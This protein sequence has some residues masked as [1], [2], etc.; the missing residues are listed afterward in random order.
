MFTTLSG[1]GY[2]C[3]MWL[4]LLVG[5]DVL[6]V[7][8]RFF[9]LTG[10]LA[11]V[12]VTTGLLSSLF[13]LKHPERAWRALSQWQSSWLS[14]EGVAAIITFA[15]TTV[16]TLSWLFGGPGAN[17]AVALGIAM[18]LCSGFTLYC[19][20][21]IYASIKAVPDWASGYTVPGYLL[22]GLAGGAVVVCAMAVLTAPMPVSPL[23]P[24]GA[25]VLILSAGLYKL[26]VWS[27]PQDR[28]D[29]N[30]GS[31]LG[32]K[33]RARNVRLVENPSTS[34]TWVQREMH[35]RVARKHARK[36]R[37]L[38]FLAGFTGPAVLLVCTLASEGPASVVFVTLAS[39]AAQ[40]GLLIERWLFFAEA[41]HRVSLYFGADHA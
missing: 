27:R 31:A 20:S 14:R 25:A 7:S 35:Y 29:V 28:G 40:I 36:L 15:P 37:K 30:A 38:A 39:V 4:G 26:L 5:T 22:L 13:H 8:A 3:F 16:F 21:M 9:L 24:I 18:V 19:T 6:P 2:G 1:T 41:R 17:F 11:L 23:L 10:L 34:E 33:E 32:M 12:L